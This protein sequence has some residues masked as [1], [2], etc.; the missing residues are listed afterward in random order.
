MG[1][2][3][4]DRPPTVDPYALAFGGD[5]MHGTKICFLMIALL[6]VLMAP[7][8]GGDNWREH[9]FTAP[10]GEVYEAAKRVVNQHYGIKTA[11]D[12]ARTVRFHIG[13]T[14]W[15]WGY[16]VGLTVQPTGEKTSESQVA[17]E[18]TGGPVFSW[19]SAKKEIKNLWGWIDEDLYKNA[20]RPDGEQKK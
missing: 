13:T 5:L 7:L 1:P 2:Q 10:A 8:S 15:S 14:A 20:Q 17:I 12:K 6:F 19:G 3:D 4:S 11:D 9:G 16:N 18:K